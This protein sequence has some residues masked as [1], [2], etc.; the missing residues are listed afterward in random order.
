M[1][2][3]RYGSIKG[4]GSGFIWRDGLIVTNA[5][6]VHNAPFLYITL[7][8]GRELLGKVVAAVTAAAAAYCRKNFS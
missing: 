1:Y 7:N 4:A 6:V 8:N 5:H 3:G 2:I